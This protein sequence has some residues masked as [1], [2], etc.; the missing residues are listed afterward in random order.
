MNIRIYCFFL[1][2]FFLGGCKKIKPPNTGADFLVP[3]AYADLCLKD[4]KIDQNTIF[5]NNQNGVF[6]LLFND[7]IASL[8]L[9]TLSNL[10]EV[11]YAD[12]FALGFSGV[13]F[14]PSQ[15]LFN[16]QSELVY[17]NLQ[18]QIKHITLKNGLLEL[19]IENHFK[20][21]LSIEI[22][23]KNSAL[24]GQE[25]QILQD[26]LPFDQNGTQVF[27]KDL[28]GAF[29]DLTGLNQLTTNKILIEY[30][31]KISDNAN[32]FI[33]QADDD[34][35]INL[36]I[37]NIE[38][39]F[40][41]GYFSS[42][43]E[44]IKDTSNIEIL[45]N[46]SADAF[47]FDQI[48]S[49]LIIENNVGA[50]A[51]VQIHQILANNSESALALN[52]PFINQSLNLNRAH[53]IEESIYPSEKTIELNSNNSN[54]T[55]IINLIPYNIF[56]DVDFTIL[57]IDQGLGVQPNFIN[58]SKGLNVFLKTDVPLLVTIENFEFTDTLSFDKE[59][60]NNQIEALDSTMLFMSYENN[61]LIDFQVS[62]YFL[63]QSHQIIDSLT[64]QIN[65]PPNNE[66]IQSFSISETNQQNLL[67]AE[68]FLVKA[69][70]NPSENNSQ[71]QITEEQKLNLQFSLKT[72]YAF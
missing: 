29:I 1:V 37:K 53:Q 65:I 15:T 23:L 54:I 49:E 45:N 59:L 7:T 6:S 64:P 3:I 2:V 32:T 43:T 4:L 14:N 18:H 36:K 44:Q 47:L 63:D 52:A 34:I 56:V 69:V 41:E 10:A 40:V 61:F 12:T 35:R 66:N 50:D 42:L 16:Q 48:Q 39:S 33:V 21:P 11:L 58:T 27:S 28:S 62:L 25:I 68:S 26:V 46:I 72:K 8:N 13:A 5:N 57:P 20:E 67:N 31:I 38:P 70:A 19:E 55:S 22:T 24:F 9:D 30:K 71:I 60:L 51:S 17:A